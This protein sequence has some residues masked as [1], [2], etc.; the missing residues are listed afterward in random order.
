M[1]NSSLLPVVMAGGAGSRLWPLSRELYPKQFLVLDGELSMLQ[2]TIMRLEGLNCIS[3]IVICNEQHRFVVAEQLRNIDKLTNNI[4]LEPV[5]R[6][7][8]PAVAVAALSSLQNDQDKDPLLLVLAADH[9]I[10]DEIKFQ[11][12][13]NSAIPLAEAGKFVTFG[14]IPSHPET[15]Y[16]YIRSGNAIILEGLVEDVPAYE[17]DEFVEKPD[18][19]KAIEYVSDGNYYWNSGMF[20]FRASRYL[21]ELKK[22]RPDILSACELAIDKSKSDLDFVRVDVESFTNCPAESI[23]Y[24]VM[25]KID[26]AV[27]VPIDA[28]WSDVGSWLSLWDISHKDTNGNVHQG[29]VISFSSNDNLVFAESALVAMVGIKDMIIV[30]TKDALLITPKQNVQ[31]VKKVVEEIK[32]RGRKEHHTHQAVYTPWGKYEAIE[33]GERYRVKKIT[34]KSGEG[35]SLRMHHHRAEHWIVVSGTALVTLGEEKRLMVSNESIYIPQGAVYSL[36][37]PGLIPLNLIEVSS[38]DYLEEDDIVRFKERYDA[39]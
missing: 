8:A 26:N 27:V 18:E 6:N 5:G 39:F 4:I 30:Q 25:E 28:G 20:L 1:N 36:E 19:N 21:E 10:K 9:T 35:L 14:I 2:A 17:V 34:V 15:G 3:P 31:D 7:T 23:D 33:Q 24:A 13:V 29:D 37:N 32:L 16:G 22:F 38:G 12:V 11:E